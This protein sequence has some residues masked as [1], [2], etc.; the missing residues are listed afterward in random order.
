MRVKSL[1]SCPA[2]CDPMDCGLPG[3]SVHG[4]RIMEWVAM[5]SSRESSRPRDWTHVSCGSCVVLRFSLLSQQQSPKPRRQYLKRTELKR[6]GEEPGYIE[7]LQQRAG[8]LNINRLLLIKEN[9]ISQVKKLSHF[10]RMGRSKSLGSLKS[11]FSICTSA[12]LG[13]YLVF[14]SH[15]VLPWGSLKGVATVLMATR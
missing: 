1:Q 10:L 12:I 9:Q 5:P 2:L 14:F 6:S 7:V 15:P 8:S 3:S 4:A 13:Q 11:F